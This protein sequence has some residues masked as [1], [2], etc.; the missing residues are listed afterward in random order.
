MPLTLNPRERSALVSGNAPTLAAALAALFDGGAH[1]R[2]PRS[3]RPRSPCPPAASSDPTLHPQRP[4]PAAAARADGRC[5]N[6]SHAASRSKRGSERRGGDRRTAPPANVA[7]ASSSAWARRL[8]LLRQAGAMLERAANGVSEEQPRPLAERG[9]GGGRRG[10]D[11]DRARRRPDRTGAGDARQSHGGADRGRKSRRG[12][13]GRGAPRRSPP[14]T[15]SAPARRRSIPPHRAAPADA[16]DGVGDRRDRL[17]D[18][19]RAGEPAEDG[20]PGR[21]PSASRRGRAAR[22]RR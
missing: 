2:S 18:A 14:R 4:P 9:D 11:V 15:A 22:G 3:S 20:A 21:R 5:R 6:A 13:A 1:L 7:T 12:R 10:P 19:A 16:S 17:L 8:D